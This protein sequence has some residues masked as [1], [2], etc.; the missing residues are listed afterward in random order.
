MKELRPETAFLLAAGLGTRLEAL[1]LDKPKALVEINGKTLLEINLLKLKNA[2]FKRVIINLHHFPQQIMAHLSTNE[3]FGLEIIFSDETTQLLDTGGALLKAYPLF[4]EEAAVL[5]HNVDI[6]TN[7]SPDKL[8][9]LMQTCNADAVMMVRERE[10]S[11]KVLLDHDQRFCGW[12]NYTSGEEKW[13]DQTH[14]DV[15]AFSFSGIHLFRPEILQNLSPEKCGL[16]D[17]FLQLAKSHLIVGSLQN[18]GYW[19]D[20]GKIRQTDEINHFFSSTDFV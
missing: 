5:V 8:A 2:G 6:L 3:N 15:E 12:R 16:I 17:L 1:T 11:R 18:E 20:Y 10:S 4:A 13:V 7:C 9:K 14:S 19:F